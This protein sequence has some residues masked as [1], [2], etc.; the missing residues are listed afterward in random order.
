M[1][2]SPIVKEFCIKE[3]DTLFSAG[4]RKRRS[5]LLELI[6]DMEF[7]LA[8][9]RSFK[10]LSLN[11][12]QNNKLV[13]ITPLYVVP[14]LFCSS[15]DLLGRVL[16]KSTPSARKSK[17]F[18]IDSAILFYEM[19]KTSAEALWQLRSSLKVFTHSSILN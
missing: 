15:I 17:A 11:E 2:V 12:I 13:E 14:M 18:F 4:T 6:R 7:N 19:G 1:A 10:E 5:V 8:Y 9:P 3:L 16:K